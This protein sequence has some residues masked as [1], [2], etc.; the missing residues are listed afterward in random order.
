MRGREKESSAGTEAGRK[1]LK[2]EREEKKRNPD[3]LNSGLPARSINWWAALAW[4][5]KVA[6]VSL[7][8]VGGRSPSSQRVTSLARAYSHVSTPCRYHHLKL[9]EAK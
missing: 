4:W 6:D 3:E 9:H 7:A 1:I 5:V 2:K 8:L